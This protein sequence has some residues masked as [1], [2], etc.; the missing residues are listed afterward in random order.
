[1]EIHAAARRKF[2]PQY[3]APLAKAA[4]QELPFAA[5]LAG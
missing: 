1:M 4:R 5:I 3:G 2:L